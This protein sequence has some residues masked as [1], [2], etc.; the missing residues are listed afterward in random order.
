[1]IVSVTEAITLIK[2]G[3]VVAIPTETVYG[4]A[5]DAENGLAV[6]KIFTLKGRPSDNPLIVHLS[7]ADQISRF[8]D[9]DSPDLRRLTDAFWPGPL[10]LIVPRKE[11]VLD[12]VTAG[13][14]SVALRM[15][16]HPD[17]LDIIRQSGPVTAPSANRSGRPSPTKPEHI[18]ADFGDNLPV[19]D[20]GECTIGIESTVLDLTSEEPVVLRPGKYSAEEL[21]DLL[22]K[23]VALS[24][25]NSEHLSKSPGTRYTHYKPDAEI[26][27]M[28]QKFLKRPEDGV[29]YIFHSGKSEHQRPNV[30]DFNQDYNALGKAL[31]DLYRT[32][33]AKK[34]TNIYIEPLPEQGKHPLLP[35][36]KNRIERSAGQ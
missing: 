21:G 6:R 25:S 22:S 26:K 17:A 2:R 10:T 24:T 7:S 16:S 20:G 23:K 35:A 14:D 11:T 9:F 5:A 36:L 34:Y 13:L 30:I 31:Y 4:L 33:D 1:M 3:E 15:P 8:T 12:V 29:L 18:F 32:A 28:P 19:V 27:W